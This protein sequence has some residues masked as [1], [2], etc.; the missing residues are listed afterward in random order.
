MAVFTPISDN[1]TKEL[2][3]KYDLPV[4]KPLVYYDVT[5]GFTKHAITDYAEEEDY[6]TWQILK[7]TLD[8]EDTKTISN[9]FLSSMQAPDFISAY[10]AE[11]ESTA[12]TAETD[13]R[14][15]IA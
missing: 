8:N 15:R 6:G 11:E 4:T 2:R 14:F 5:D 3:K 9:K 12:K 13:K 1:D 10:R 7:I